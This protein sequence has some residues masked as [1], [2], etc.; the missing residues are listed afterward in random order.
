M[1]M[2]TRMPGREVI[3]RRGADFGL[4]KGPWSHYTVD[5]C[6]TH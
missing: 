3:V 6:L 5:P 2:V 1:A 4:S